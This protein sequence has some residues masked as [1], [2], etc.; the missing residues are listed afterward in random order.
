[1][2]VYIYTQTSVCVRIVYIIKKDTSI[3]EIS[4]FLYFCIFIINKINTLFG[5]LNSFIYVII[6][7]AV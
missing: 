5:L 3:Y 7:W 1:M 6:Y 4:S 2:C